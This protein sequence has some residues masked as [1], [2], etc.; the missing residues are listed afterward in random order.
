MYIPTVILY[1]STA[2]RNCMAC[3]QF[4]SAFDLGAASHAPYICSAL[5]QEPL[6]K[7]DCLH[8][9]NHIEPGDVVMLQRRLLWECYV[10]DMCGD[11]VLELHSLQTAVVKAMGHKQQ[12]NV[13]QKSVGWIVLRRWWW[14]M[15]LA[16]RTSNDASWSMA[17]DGPWS[18]PRKD[19]WW[20]LL[21]VGWT[22]VNSRGHEAS[23][24]L[25]RWMMV[26]SSFRVGDHV[27]VGD[28]DDNDGSY[29]HDRNY[30]CDWNHDCDISDNGPRN[31]N[32]ILC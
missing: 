30:H 16:P 27:P 19:G 25:I 4:F 13:G 10:Q 23:W 14:S 17:I 15:I 32:S 31:M 9:K 24:R 6:L 8:K 20:L 26:H 7:K 28:S 12:T 1:I 2:H 29:D 3:K 21:Q 22:W 18:L 11:P 5:S